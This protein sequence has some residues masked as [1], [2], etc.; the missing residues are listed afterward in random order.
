MASLQT[1]RESMEGAIPGEGIAQV[2]PLPIQLDPHSVERI[3][4]IAD[5]IQDDRNLDI[6]VWRGFGRGRRAQEEQRPQNP[7]EQADLLRDVSLAWLASP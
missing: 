5:A 2:N 6:F 4:R 1:A 7:Q 3:G